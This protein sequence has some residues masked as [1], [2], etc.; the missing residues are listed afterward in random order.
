M[1]DGLYNFLTSQFGVSVVL[2][3]VVLGVLLGA[4]A[5]CIYFERKISAWIQDRWGPNRVGPAGLF[6]PIADGLKF[7]FKEDVIPGNV[8][9]PL[10]IAA[11]AIMFL[12]GFI[13]FAVIPWGG[14]WEINGKLID[15]QVASL[16][17]GL[18][19][20]LGVASMGVYGVV[21]G[22]WSSNNKYSIFGGIRATAQMLSYEI[23]MGLC[24]L[25]VVL[26]LGTVRLEE[27][28]APQA[29]YWL[30]F[31]PKWN[32]FLH[33][34]AFVVLFTT[35]LAEANRA[36]FDLAEAE[37]ELI[38]GFHTEY[39]ALKFGM[40]F[41]AEYA[42][43]ITSSAFLAVLFLGGYH[44]PGI[45]WTQPDV[46]HFGAVLAKILVLS[47]KVAICIFVMM[48]VRWTLPRFRFD[49]LMRLAW[50]GLIPLMLVLFV[51]TVV[52]VYLGEERSPLWALGGNVVALVGTLVY[53]GLS[54]A[55]ITGRT[56]NL[57]P[58]QSA[59]GGAMAGMS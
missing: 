47:G 30:G 16:D 7:V 4:V 42:A 21:L 8:D 3:L 11:P 18:L 49:Q 28:I 40:F 14:Y 19:Y 41:L 50:S 23:P 44:F 43:M 45:A 37:Q 24:I 36:P 48:W 51:W 38:G 29:Q 10:F 39:S 6:Q 54:K 33:P 26:T 2:A 17:I 12:V 13:G 56:S 59:Q 15:I 1:P 32:V 55:E 34:I 22:A 53:A 25:I 5:Y 35:M 27:M 31:I 52:L 9:K 20:I 57:P 58:V 46:T